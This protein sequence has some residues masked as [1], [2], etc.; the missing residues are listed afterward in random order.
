MEFFVGDKV[1]LLHSTESGRVV[2][3]E[4]SLI[5]VLTS[6]G[7][8]I[9]VMK[10]E[11]ILEDMAREREAL[12]SVPHSERHSSQPKGLFLG[13]IE[14]GSS[15]MKQVVFINTTS[16]EVSGQ[17]LEIKKQEKELKT[18]KLHSKLSLEP[19]SYLELPGF[20]NLTEK[21]P[22]LI[23]ELN[24]FNRGSFDY[25]SALVRELHIKANHFKNMIDLPLLD[26]SGYLI[27][28]EG[29]AMPKVP[30]DLGEQIV[31]NQR[32]F[33]PVVEK[34][35]RKDIELDLHIQKLLDE[36]VYSGWDSDGIL[37]YQVSEAEKAMD[38][39]SMGMV[40]KLTL[41]HGLGNGVLKEKLQKMISISQHVETYKDAKRERFGYGALDV[42]F[43]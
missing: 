27:E 8:E 19:N 3:V 25:K 10:D 18:C 4:G 14:S 5:H 31:E 37:N 39:A 11:V 26:R 13:I 34:T 23:L 38:E 15:P 41:I 2:R 17:I 12:S 32:V 24:F 28:L 35:P 22:S 43:K 16:Y 1:S 7:F 33:E 9:P 42:F 29:K 36:S 30:V 21:P 40:N 20:M 6:D